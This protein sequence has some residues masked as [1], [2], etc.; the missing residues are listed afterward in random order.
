MLMCIL[1]PRIR[2]E[3][4]AFIVSKNWLHLCILRM[5]EV[6]TSLFA[7]RVLS[8]LIILSV[9][10]VLEMEIWFRRIKA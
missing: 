3:C 2:C 5:V 8:R 7:L 6:K 9:L 4:G 1:M 10:R